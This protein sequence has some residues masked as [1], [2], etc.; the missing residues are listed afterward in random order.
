[1][2]EDERLVTAAQRGDTHAFEALVQR[3]QPRVIRTLFHLLGN[4]AEADDAAQEVWIR[5]YRKLPS[6]R[7]DSQFS[8]WLYRITSNEARSAL[9]RSS[10]HRSRIVG[11]SVE[12]ISPADG[13]PGPRRIL[14]GQEMARR[15]REVFDAMPVKRRLAVTLVLFEDLSHRQAGDILGLSE[16][17]VSWHLFK[18]REFLSRRLHED[19]HSSSKSEGKR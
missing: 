6:F 5:V 8:T 17:T 1:M 19:G 16:K 9:R 12:E 11:P 2:E 18:A 14:E 15:F 10:R 3:H 7:M 4:E 13:R